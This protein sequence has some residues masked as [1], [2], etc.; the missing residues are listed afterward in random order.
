MKTPGERYDPYQ[1]ETVQSFSRE[2]LRSAA[3]RAE[4]TRQIGSGALGAAGERTADQEHEPYLRVASASFASPRHPE[5]SDD[6]LVASDQGYIGVFDGVGSHARSERAAEIAAVAADNHLQQIGAACTAREAREKIEQYLNKAHQAIGR[7]NQ[8]NNLETATT[9]SVAALVRSGD[10]RQL[11]YGSV[12]DSRIAVYRQAQGVLSTL[13][14]DESFVTSQ[15]SPGQRIGIQQAIDH[16][17]TDQDFDQLSPAAAYAYRSRN[18]V[19]HALGHNRLA[20]H[21]QTGVVNVAPGDLVLAMTDGVHD[22][23]ALPHIY[24]LVRQHHDDPTAVAE[25]LSAASHA[26][27]TSPDAHTVRSKEDDAAV[28]VARVE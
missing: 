27:M 12:G 26:S 5:H 18:I 13:T 25:A 10:S 21:L 20:D 15:L 28:V 6:R 9:A 22:N 14:L 23:L 4:L 3:D 24:R 7:Y 8:Q 11:A 2:Q 17:Q 1:S 19:S 16:M